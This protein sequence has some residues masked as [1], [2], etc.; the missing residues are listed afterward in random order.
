MIPYGSLAWSL[1]G[2]AAYAS[3]ASAGWVID[4][5]MKGGDEAGRQQV[6]LQAN[7][8]RT[9][10]LGPDGKPEMAFILDLNGE[11]ITQ[12]NYRERTYTS[13]KVQEYAQMIQGAVKGAMSEVEKAMKDM[14]AE[15]RQMMEQ[16]MGS[17]MP[18]AGSNPGDC[19]EPRIEMRKTGQQATIA[20]YPAVGYEVVADGKSESELW[21]AKGITA[22]KELDPKKLERVMSELAKVAPRCGPAS[23]RQAGMGEDQAW[24]L[25][26]E[27]YPV[28]TVD[29]RGGNTTVEVVKAESRT[30]PASEFQPPANFTRQTLNEMMGR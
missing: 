19:R 9:L 20:G 8:M 25:A 1:L 16:M 22:W 27:G 11:T 12:V 10:M 17:K 6:V 30:V 7:Q 13:A 5:V 26:G 24:K 4:Q 14:P 18:K 21:I 28:K 15:Q 23:G 29:R 3:Q 2:I